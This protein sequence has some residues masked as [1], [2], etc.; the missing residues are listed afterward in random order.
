MPPKKS[1][2]TPPTPSKKPK[3]RKPVLRSPKFKGP[4]AHLLARR[5]RKAKATA[6][7]PDICYVTVVGDPDGGL[8]DVGGWSTGP[9]DAWP[10]DRLI[11]DLWHLTEDWH[12]QVGKGWRIEAQLGTGEPAE[13]PADPYAMHTPGRR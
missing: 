4:L 6:W 10:L 1:R 7:M 8:L 9:S 2:K 12:A 11:F 13:L 3:K 5:V